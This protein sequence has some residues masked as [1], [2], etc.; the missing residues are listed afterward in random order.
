MHNVHCIDCMLYGQKQPS[1]GLP[2]YLE[3]I[4]ILPLWV[5]ETKSI[6]SGS[7]LTSAWKIS[8]QMRWGVVTSAMTT[9]SRQPSLSCFAQMVH[10]CRTLVTTYISTIFNALYN[11]SL[12]DKGTSIQWL[13]KKQLF[14]I[15]CIHICTVLMLVFRKF[16]C[17]SCA[18]DRT[19]ALA[20]KFLV[21][22]KA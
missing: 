22:F 12:M 8:W 4:G 18:H 21:N 17:L 10:T 11:I 16:W 5:W 6:K 20:Q 3:D 13:T 2:S 7:E 19:N 9:T 14:T 1:S 15:P